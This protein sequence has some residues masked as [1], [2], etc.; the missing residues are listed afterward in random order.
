MSSLTLRIVIATVILFGLSLNN[1]AYSA[2]PNITFEPYQFEAGDGTVVEAER[3]S[4]EVPENRNNPDARNIEIQFVRFKSTS[5]NPGAPIVYL[6][7]GPGG[8]GVGTAR[9]RRF[10]L[11]MAMREFGDV[12][13]FDQRGTGW[14]NHI[15]EC[16]TE[17]RFPLDQPL[18]REHSIPVLRQAA[19]ECATFWKSQG[20]DL[21]GYNTLES[22]R[23]INALRQGL[24]VEKLTLW[25]ISYGSHLAMAAVKV[26][27][28]NINRM[29]LT[30]I[31]GLNATVKLPARTD[32]YFQRLQDAINADSGAAEAFP[33]LAGLMRNVHAKLEQQPINA[34]FTDEAGETVNMTIGKLEMQMVGSFSIADPAS[35][36]RLPAIYAMAAA[37]DVSRIAPFIYDNLRRDPISFSG[38]PE[39]M[40]IM[41]GISSQRLSLV[42]QQ[43]ETS[44][45][46][47]LLNFPMPHLANSFGLS[48]LGD[49][50][51]TQVTTDVPTLILTSTLDGRTYP[52][53]AIEAVSGPAIHRVIVENGGHNVFM[54]APE[55][56]ELIISYMRGEK[57]PDSV[58]LAPPKFLF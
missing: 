33:D 17:H 25:G 51:R 19:N 36:A 27:P 12:I 6:A 13:A 16:E 3:G 38:M 14:S 29:V 24:G 18:T 50:F 55:I 32:A 10:P 1:T 54:Q 22:A 57:T 53:G 44:L 58:T 21:A 15:T 34:V 28:D 23:D 35:A 52:E 11:F 49:G 56:S 39:A 9:G 43:A 4:F 46:G 48:D 31:E 42:N 26:M 7:G 8:S 2:T 5:D 41:S 20:V 45:L 37:G 47:D 40:D 30:G